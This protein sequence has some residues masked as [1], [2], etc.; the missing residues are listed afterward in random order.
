M[1]YI[2]HIAILAYASQHNVKE[3]IQCHP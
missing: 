3:W 1:S 2:Y